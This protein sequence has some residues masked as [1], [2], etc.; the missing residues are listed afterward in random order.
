MSRMLKLIYNEQL[1]I[2]IRKST[3]AMYIILGVIIIGLAVMTNSFGE[4]GEQYQGDDWQEVLQQENKELQKEGEEDEFVG[5][6]NASII[7]ENN[8][9]L[10]NNIQPTPYGAWQ[11]LRENMLLLSVVSLLTII[12]AAGIV[13]NEFRWGTIKL[14]L[15]RPISRSGILLSKY[16][17]V[18]L[19][20]LFTSIFVFLFS[21][22]I[23]AIFFGVEGMNPS[24]V[25]NEASGYTTISLIPT[26]F[27]EYGYSMVNLVMMTTFAF[28]ISTV[29][30]N[31]ALAIGTAIFL[32]MAG[33]S[34]VG[35]FQDKEWA[36]YILFANTDLSQYADGR[37]PWIEG[38]TI[39]FSI[40]ML[41]IY[42]VVFIL[43]SW[44]FFTKRDV[45]GQ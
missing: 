6:L 39:G 41:I 44:L 7:E 11:F 36:K 24:I 27:S 37:T 33:N 12:I 25:S 8:Y 2:Y 22:I 35:F 30:R 14:L 17:S 9:Y 42:Y 29:F 10:D 3:W 45:A 1:K 26:I 18:L 15:I 16:I 21:F 40:T 31:S 32:M 20:A 19:F 13:A 34:I 38:M 43:L 23:G 28:M 5:S 4:L